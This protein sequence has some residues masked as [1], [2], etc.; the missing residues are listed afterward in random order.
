MIINYNEEFFIPDSLTVLDMQISKLSMNSKSDPVS[1]PGDE[2]S[3]VLHGRYAIGDTRVSFP[4]SRSS[5][6]DDSPASEED[7][8]PS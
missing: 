4:S 1:F 5:L 8:A 2:S 7:R 3:S 6:C